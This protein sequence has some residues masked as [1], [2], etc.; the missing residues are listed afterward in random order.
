MHAKGGVFLKNQLENEKVLDALKVINSYFEDK[1]KLSA[2]QV[3]EI[4]KEEKKFIPVSAFE[5]SGL[6]SLEIIVRYMKNFLKLSYHEIAEALNRDDRTIWC[7]YSNSLRKRKNP[8]SIKPSEINIPVATVAERKYS[9]LESI[10]IFLRN[11]KNLSFNEISLKLKKNY[12]TV[13][14]TYRKALK[15]Y[16]N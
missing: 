13:W 8:L 3:L 16:E 2:A 7:T 11:K 4:V 1:Y 6:S 12:Q 5:N 15:K 9:V 10:V 14:T